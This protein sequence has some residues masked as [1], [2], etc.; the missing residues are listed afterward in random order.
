MPFS[1]LILARNEE[2]NLP[3]CL[4]AVAWCDDVVVVDDFSTDQTTEIAA[5]HGARVVQRRFDTFAGQ[6]NFALDV[7]AFRYG[8]VFHLDADEI[9][10][11]ALRA[12]AEVAVGTARCRAYRVPSKMFLFG[13]WLR[14]AAT[15]PAYQVRLGMNPG[16]RFV[17]VGH[18][19]REDLAPA[20]I[21]TLH[22]PYL[23]FPFSKGL[24]EWFDKHNRYSSGEAR[25]GADLLRSRRVRWSDLLGADPTER[26]RALKDLSVRFPFRPALRFW[27]LYLVRRGFLDGRAGLA[28]C[29]LMAMYERMIVLKM[30][31]LAPTAYHP[32]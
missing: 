5:T 27:Y 6:R 30:A 11:P 24:E 25:A 23:H 31:E 7:V 21:G 12:E 19:Q 13:T 26:R 10:T 14:H 15:Y 3:R 17:Q 20:L 16:L 32:R 22:E 4:E 8:W 9:F 2:V 18:G 1:I 28:Y 29:R